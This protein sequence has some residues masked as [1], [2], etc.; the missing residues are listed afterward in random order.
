MIWQSCSTESSVIA[1]T[2]PHTVHFAQCISLFEMTTQT[3]QLD[4]GT[5]CV[6][7]SLTAKMQQERNRRRWLVRDDIQATKAVQKTV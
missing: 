5:L 2:A 3:Q 4:K 6:F 1:S 7:R